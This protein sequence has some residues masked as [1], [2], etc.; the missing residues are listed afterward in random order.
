MQVT[1]IPVETWQTKL[2]LE[3]SRIA[4][5]RSEH[6]YVT[7]VTFQGEEYL[8]SA[9]LIALE[10]LLD[11]VAIR[12]NRNVL[13]SR[14]FDTY[15][16]TCYPTRRGSPR[17]LRASYATCGA[18]SLPVSRRMKKRVAEFVAE[19]NRKRANPDGH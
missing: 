15:T 2:D 18:I 1:H 5:L 9:S 3:V 8:S 4:Y 12:I 10:S 19:H 7:V 17:E 13:V 14:N 16:L 11:D 6:K